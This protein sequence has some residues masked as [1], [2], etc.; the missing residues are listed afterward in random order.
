MPGAARRWSISTARSLTLI[1]RDASDGGPEPPASH[2]PTTNS[3]RICPPL[4]IRLKASRRRKH[5]DRASRAGGS[6]GC[7][8]VFAAATA[9]AEYGGDDSEARHRLGRQR[10]AGPGQ[11]ARRRG[12]VLLALFAGRGMQG[13]VEYARGTALRSAAV[14]PERSAVSGNARWRG[15]WLR[16]ADSDQQR[17]SEARSSDCA[18]GHKGD[19]PNRVS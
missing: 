19:T 1:E 6:Y 18:H 16:H 13:M 10:G 7:E 9:D 15:S 11:N 8:L 12:T 2:E 17:C 14:L 5:E 3:R 4:L